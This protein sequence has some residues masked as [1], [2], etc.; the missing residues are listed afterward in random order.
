M[1]SDDDGLSWEEVSHPGAWFNAFT[2][3]SDAVGFAGGDPDVIHRTAD[4]GT[5]WTTIPLSHP[6]GSGYR[7]SDLSAPDASTVVVSGFGASRGG[8]FRSVDG[9]LSWSFASGG[10]PA[11][12]GLNTVSFVDAMTGYA[13]TGGAGGSSLYRTIDG[14]ASWQPMSTVG[15][16][17]AIRDM[18][19]YDADEGLIAGWL[20]PGGIIRTENGGDDWEPVTDVAVRFLVPLGGG[21]LLAI[22]SQGSAVLISDDRGRT[23]TPI[24]TVLPDAP[25]C[26]VSLGAGDFLVGG[27]ATRVV[28]IDRDDVVAVADAED[29]DPS[30][31]RALRAVGTTP[32]LVVSGVEG[33]VRVVVHDVMGRRV[34]TLTGVARVGSPTELRW[35]GT[36]H[37]GRPMAPG[38]YLA[39]LEGWSGSAVRLVLTP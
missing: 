7:V 33:P 4:G 25:Q 2:F 5:T 39:R 15:F 12:Q 38:L 29:P 22:P 37:H 20:S 18:H 10:L 6:L 24:P 17:L 1:R 14:G 30:P 3:V 26:G 11:N 34:A 9:G 31:L 28:R 19:W 35:T 8:V 16:P 13:G 27:N 32:T 21:S 36:N 23:W